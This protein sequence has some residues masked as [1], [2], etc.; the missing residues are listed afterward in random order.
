MLNP[1]R[2][3]GSL[4]RSW[5]FSARRSAQALGASVGIVALALAVCLS[6]H[7]AP[8][9]SASDSG[10]L[11]VN[12]VRSA[13][14]LNWRQ[15]PGSVL[16]SPGRNSV[17]LDPC[18]PGVFAAEPWY[19]VYISGTG[20]PE[21]VRVTGG[22]CKGDSRPGTLEFTT[23]NSHP[24]GYVVSSASSGI[25]EASIAARFTPTNPKGIPQSGRVVIPPGEYDVFAPI[26]IR[27]S[28]QTIDFAGSV[29]NCYTPNDA[30]VFVGDPAS[31]NAFENITLNGPRGRPMMVAGTKPFIEVNGQ[32]TRI[33]NVTTRLPSHGGS[34]GSYVQVDDDQSF[35]LDGL[36][37]TLGAEGVTCNPSYCGAFVTAPGPFHRWAAVGWLKHL[38]LSLQCAGKGV[39]WLSG[40]GLRISDSVIQGWSVF[41]VRVSNQRGG[42]GGFVSDNV[43][44]EAAN[45]KDSS[46]MGNVGNA[47]ILAEGVQVK[48]SGLAN[49]G[50]SGVFPNWGARAGSRDWLYWVVPVHAQ[51]GDGVPL[52][53]GHALNNG[54]GSVTGTFPRIAGASSYKILKIDWDQKTTPPFP[55]GTGDYLVTTVQQSSCATLVCQFTDN[56]GKLTSYTNVGENLA[57][58]IYMPR[59]DFWPGAIV[60]SSGADMSTAAYHSFAPPLQ[61][62][63]LGIGAIVS[64]IPSG[65]VTGQAHSLIM[66]GAIPTAAASLE[67][68]HTNG[69]GDIPAATILKAA[70]GLATKENSL[71]GRLNFGHRGLDIGFTP[72]ITLGD[73]NWGKTWATGNHR[74]AADANDLD[75]GYEGNIDTFYSRAQK[76]VREYIG[77]FPDGSPQEKLS[78]SAKTFN[79]PVTINGNLTVTGKCVGC[80]G[81]SGSAGAALS[82]T[83]ARWSVSLTGQKAAIAPTNLCASSA[84]GPG[85]YQVSYYLDSTAACSSP[86]NAAAAVTIGWKDE[87][88][89]RTIRVPLAGVGISG[90]NSLSLGGTSNFGG[91]N[92]S[93]WSAGN[94]AI[95]YST[96]Y[97]SCAAG[98]G[99]YALRIAVEKVQ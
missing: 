42:Y 88:T 67:A 39:D 5:R 93:L 96:S 69:A 15:S 74:P 21:A 51:F 35:L 64:T 30:C 90:G 81:D 4:F 91:G 13:T 92:I 53:A 86:G 18:P 72:L 63:V 60:I 71:K 38:V 70:N 99:N 82:S 46:P 11:A 12:I 87:T 50:A 89:S 68:L 8:Y 62:D 33:F 31:S 52:P 56:G 49:N 66:S 40:N 97:T 9:A 61:A 85:Q 25:Q 24:S 94:A 14:D 2:F 37:S 45:C 80:A 41:G 95:T 32:Q 59:L 29:L 3:P 16:S 27:A 55:E 34:F 78:A 23:V 22:T 65:A 44:Y 10:P 28:S 20:S 57:K 26:S 73:S 48:M 43:Y 47:A 17:T 84:C 77:K 83:G 76:E 79:V 6:V 98:A 19:Y 7:H 75:L 1:D 36:D 58:N 54:S